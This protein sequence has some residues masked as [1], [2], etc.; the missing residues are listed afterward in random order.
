MA[1]YCD[2]DDLLAIRPDVL[3][4]GV[5]SW[6]DQIIEAGR[7]IDRA[8]DSKWYRDAAAEVGVDARK[9]PFDRAKLRNAD[10]QLK[11]L[12]SYKSLELAYL[13][14]MKNQVDDAFNNQMTIFGKL[15]SKELIEVL[16]A[17]LDYD[18]DAS[19]GLSYDEKHIPR[20]RRQ[21]RM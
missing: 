18:F 7:V 20:T 3:K 8:L 2:D 6:D 16:A 13:H 1:E 19:G 4:L 12:G 15:Y 17:G 11:R 5:D 21:M 10:T 9:T 14:L